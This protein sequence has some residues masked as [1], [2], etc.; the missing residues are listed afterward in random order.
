MEGLGDL[1]NILKLS[2]D[3]LQKQ[4]SMVENQ[5]DILK[6]DK[7]VSDEDKDF[8]KNINSRL[9]NAMK[10]SDTDSLNVLMTEIQNKLNK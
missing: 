8:I 2:K 9:L 6:K 7:S 10:N 1:K 4:K 5:M 3:M